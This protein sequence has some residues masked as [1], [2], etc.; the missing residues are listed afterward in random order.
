[1]AVAELGFRIKSEEAEVADKRLTGMADASERAEAGTDRLEKSSG[2]LTKALG[3]AVGRMIAF[4]AAAVSVGSAARTLSQFEDGMAR[5]GAITRATDADLERLRETAKSLGASTEFSATQAANG[6]TFLGQA[7][8][9]AAESMAAIPAVLDLATASG[10]D[11][12][13]AADTASNIMSGFGISADEAASVADVLAAASS[14]ANTNV[15]QLGQAMSTVAPIAKALGVDLN[16]TAAAIG[17]MSDAGIQGERAGTALRG[18]FASLAGPTS[19]AADTL[20]RYGLAAADVNPEAHGLST[21]LDTL[22]QRGVSTADAM[23]IFGR[24]AASGALVLIEASDR[25]SEFTDELSDAGG[26]AGRMAETMRSSLGGSFKTL[27]SSVEAFILALGDAGLTAAI[28]AAVKAMTMLVRVGTSGVEMLSDY[29]GQVIAAAAAA[30]AYFIPSMV[31]TVG[32][33]AT[34]I[35]STATWIASLVTLRGVL[36]ATGIG[37]FVVLAGTLINAMLRL[38][39]STGGWGAALKLLGEVASGVWDGIKI[40]AQAIEPAL[41]AVWANV[42]AAFLRLLQSMKAEWA[43]FLR[44]LSVGMEG[45][46]GFGNLQEQIATSA[47]AASD[48]IFELDFAA[49]SLEGKA[50]RLN[51]EAQSLASDGFDTAAAAASKLAAAV[52]KTNE[53]LSVPIDA[54]TVPSTGDTPPPP[55]SSGGGGGGDSRIQKLIDS[56]KTEEEILT[57]WYAQA[58]LD[59]LTANEAELEIIGGHNEAKLRLEAEYNDRL[60][61]LQE[62][63]AQYVRGAQDA[64]QGAAL[65]FLS[66]LSGQSEGAAKALLAINTGL[67]ISE[68]IQNTAV[69]ATR[70]LA[71]LG[72]IAGPIAAARVKAYGAAQVGLIAAN[73]ALRLG[74]SSGGGGA[75]GGGAASVS[76]ASSSAP[77]PAPQDAVIQLEGALADVLAPLMDSIVSELQS[78]SEDGVNIVGVVAR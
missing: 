51:K 9:T 44:A 75:G 18:V 61:Q 49:S 45:I 20:A 30:T 78:R 14:R 29:K 32:V 8:F 6:L 71:E 39:Q 33:L 11:L 31:A 69:A 24:E 25:V 13:A 37:A 53:A 73:A 74:S 2:K 40:G 26:E 3:T 22:R 50:I 67:S 72:P 54:G 42:N 28:N 12:A 66:T 47:T 48:S 21:V 65:D 38:V 76:T 15:S 64:A 58:Q 56:L 36:I 70:A 41:A 16:E 63:Q 35:A 43:A 46:P 1:M 62:D 52:D 5:L 10:M 59:L 4:A 68:A 19:Q 77:A 27:A 55:G 7:G 17:V 57:E 34:A 60:R 23:T